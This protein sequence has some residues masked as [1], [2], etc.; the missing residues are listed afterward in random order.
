[1]NP[2]TSLEALRAGPFSETP[3]VGHT[4]ETQTTKC[5]KFPENSY[6]KTILLSFILRTS[7]DYN[8]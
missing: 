6:L 3:Q 1:M 7:G 8:F 5:W 2:C 4:E